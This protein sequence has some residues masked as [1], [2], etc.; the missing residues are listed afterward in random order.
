MFN[1]FSKKKS[2]LASIGLNV[3]TDFH[4]HILPGLDDGAQDITNSLILIRGLM[5]IGYTKLI[6][7]PHVI[8]DTYRNS[9]ETILP[10]LELL[11]QACKDQHIEIELGAAAEYMLDDCFL[12]L[13]RTNTPLLTIDGKL[14]LTELSY[15]TPTG[16]LH[17]IAFEMITNNYKPILA[18]PERYFY[19]HDNYEIYYTLKEYG[20]LFQVNLLSL[21]GYYGKAVAKA[22]H[23]L[24]EQKI[25]DFVGTDMHHDRQL[26]ALLKQDNLKH[27]NNVLQGRE[28]N[29]FNIPINHLNY[30]S[31]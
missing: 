3:S 7:S 14:L 25:V 23:W 13:L 4:S 22:A 9:S 20:F 5:S 2:A 1:L 12:N 29:N 10:A 15:A 30:P 24:F 17:E 18:H 11:K 21:V 16:N 27:L 26:T 31:P 8:A 19:Y 28:Y 6:G